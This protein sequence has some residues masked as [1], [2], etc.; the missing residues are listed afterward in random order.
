MLVLVVVCSLLWLIHRLAEFGLG[1]SASRL[2]VTR[3]RAM[4]RLAFALVLLVAISYEP[5]RWL[6]TEINPSMAASD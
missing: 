2:H 5:L 1:V 4:M 6:L 3:R